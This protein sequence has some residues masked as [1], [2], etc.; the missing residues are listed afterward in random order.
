M[1]NINTYQATP[2]DYFILNRESGRLELHIDKATYQALD[3]D[4]RKRIKAAFFWGRFNGCWTS[5]RTEP[6]L[7][8]ARA[9]ANDLGLY[10]AGEIGAQAEKPQRKAAASCA[11]DRELLREQYGMVWGT[12]HKMVDYC[13][14]KVS[15]MA[16]LPGGEIIVVDKERIETRFCFGESGYDFD[17]AVAA[18]QHART[19]ADYF[20]RENMKRFDEWLS[21]LVDAMGDDGRYKLCIMTGGAYIGQG[22]ACRLHNIELMRFTDIIDACGGSCY[23]S[24]LPERELEYRGRKFRVATREEHEIILQ[25]YR[26]AAK[27]HERKVDGYLKRYGTSKVHAWTYWR[28][29]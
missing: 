3:E 19:S 11:P 22:E 2:D 25:A 21:D 14:G 26:E 13:V 27:D 8:N 1:E 7:D 12:D 16:I 10:D 24:E 18:A 4:T 20:K 6:D 28:D 23:A 9:V 15:R 5:R 29:A 17:E